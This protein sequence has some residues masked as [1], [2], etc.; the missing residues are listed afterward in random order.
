MTREAW[1]P[2]IPDHNPEI[3]QTESQG[4][5]ARRL[6]R[7]RFADQAELIANHS[8][9]LFTGIGG[10]AAFG[11]E[12]VI[13]TEHGDSS[14]VPFYVNLEEKFGRVP[15]ALFLPVSM[16][17]A[18]HLIGLL[19][20]AQECRNQ[21][22]KIIMPVLTAFAH[23]RQDHYWRD[24]D[25]SRIQQPITLDTV[26]KILLST[27]ADGGGPLIDGAA[28][29]GNHSN[30]AMI[31]AAKYGFPLL[32]EDP[33][34]FMVEK[35]DLRNWR[36]YWEYLVGLSPDK[37][38]KNEGIRLAHELGIPYGGCEKSRAR[39][40]NGDATVVLKDPKLLEYIR[41]TRATV[42]Y[43]DDEIREATTMAGGRLA[44]AG[45]ARNLV[46]V[47]FKGIFGGLRG[48]QETAAELLAK[49]LEV[50]F[51]SERIIVSDAVSPVRSIKP[52]EA[53]LITVPLAGELVNMI[54]YIQKNPIPLNEN[55]LREPEAGLLE[56]NL[57]KETYN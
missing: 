33:Y 27:P 34:N 31:V 19:S 9:I 3:S 21:G 41:A 47:A 29:I 39:T 43:F 5:I 15:Q 7:D 13:P 22:V 8:E 20:L 23:E 10:G 48:R 18:D 1:Q 2:T 30:R 32:P 36:S 16:M 37:G 12:K 4:A 11:G 57:V 49:P 53:K 24:S 46:I 55:W 45:A 25:G 35:S 40:T 26:V 51:E 44:V 56:L 52:I 17:F 54:Q 28:A 50:P 42:V 14:Q 6:W 38:R